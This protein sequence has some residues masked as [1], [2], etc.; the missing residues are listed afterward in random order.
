[1]ILF[2]ILHVVFSPATDK[3]N[4]LVLPDKPILKFLL[5]IDKRA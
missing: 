1:M 5:T 4:W 2:R 3:W